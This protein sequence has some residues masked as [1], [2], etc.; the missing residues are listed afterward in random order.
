MST[1]K[2]KSSFTGTLVPSCMSLSS[3]SEVNALRGPEKFLLGPELLRSRSTSVLSRTPWY[4]ASMDRVS[5][6]VKGTH[7]LGG[8]GGFSSGFRLPLMSCGFRLG[9]CG[10]CLSAICLQ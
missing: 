3:V 4:A 7:F 2:R 8:W 6:F 9:T 10:G 5:L 1:S